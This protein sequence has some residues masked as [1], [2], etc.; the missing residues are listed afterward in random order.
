M[1]G[2]ILGAGCVLRAICL[3]G[4]SFSPNFH[5]VLHPIEGQFVPP[6]FSAFFSRDLADDGLYSNW[7]VPKINFVFVDHKHISD[8]MCL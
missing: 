2:R 1:V 4:K 3:G 6:S 5:T 7:S 8:N